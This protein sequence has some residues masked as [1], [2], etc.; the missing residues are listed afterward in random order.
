MHTSLKSSWL[1][2]IS[3]QRQIYTYHIHHSPKNR[4]LCFVSKPPHD[5]LHRRPAPLDCSGRSSAAWVLVLR[6]QQP[7]PP[8]CSHNNQIQRHRADPHLQ[9][10]ER[11]NTSKEW[12][13]PA[14]KLGR[15]GM[16]TIPATD[17]IWNDCIREIRRIDCAS[18]ELFLFRGSRVLL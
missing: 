14:G 15:A 6:A 4:L 9:K 17:L 3:G 10:K 12:L 5:Y 2:G 1:L 13:C 7:C 18:L 8:P 11:H 16:R